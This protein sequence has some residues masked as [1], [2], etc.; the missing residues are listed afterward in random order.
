MPAHSTGNLNSGCGPGR[1]RPGQE[2]QLLL[3]ADAQDLLDL[4]RAVAGGLEQCRGHRFERG[5]KRHHSPALLVQGPAGGAPATNQ[6]SQ[7]PISAARSGSRSKTYRR[8]IRVSSR[9][10]LA[11]SSA[12]RAVS[13]TLR[14]RSSSCSGL[15]MPQSVGR[16]RRA[17]PGWR[18]GPTSPVPD[19]FHPDRQRQC[20]RRCR[21][22]QGGGP[23]PQASSIA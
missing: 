4:G 16:Q 11:S 17:S 21:G 10:S 9:S 22:P 1:W 15:G 6:L 13:T 12:S 20:R 7:E 3:L 23:R 8:R 19:K 5:G 18:P 2:P 14:R